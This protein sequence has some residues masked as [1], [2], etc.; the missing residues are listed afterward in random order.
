VSTSVSSAMGN[1]IN[2]TLTN[3]Q[4][5]VRYCQDGD[6]EIANNSAERS[7]RQIVVG[8]NNWL[9][10]GSDQGGR[11]GA[12][13]T[14]LIATCKRLHIEPL[15]YLVSLTNPS[16]SAPEECFEKFMLFCGAGDHAAR[17]LIRRAR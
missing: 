13:L 12:A 7:L 2:Y 17:Q 9:F 10:Y 3:W 4:A 14:T 6:L 1:A 5:L 16:S 15:V 11:R 8:R